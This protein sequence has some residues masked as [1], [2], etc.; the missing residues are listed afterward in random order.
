MRTAPTWPLLLATLSLTL[1]ACGDKGDDDDTGADTGASGTDVD[2]D[3]FD[4]SVDCDDEDPAVNPGATEICDDADV[5][6]DCSGDADDADAGVDT[7]TQTEAFP[8]ADADGYGDAAATATLYCDAPS[9]MVADATD[10]DDTDAAVNPGA[11][12]VC[13]DADVDEDCS[14]AADDA[15]AGVDTSTMTEVFPDDDADGYGDD[16]AAGASYCDP[17]SGLV[18]DASDCD[19]ANGDISPAATEVCDGVDN[20]CDGDA[21]TG[22]CTTCDQLSILTYYQSFSSV[23]DEPADAA[24]AEL[25]AT[26]TATS[27]G[28]TFG[29]EYD[30]ATWDIIV[31]DAP[32]SS[33]PTDV[34]A[35][36][37]TQ[38]SSGGVVLFSWWDLDSDASLATTLGVTV[39]SS[40]NTPMQMEAPST[41]TLWSIAETLP[42][43]IA[44]YSHDAGDN[45]DIV[46]ADDP[47][48]SEQ[49]AYFDGDTSMNAITAT[50]SGQVIVNGF[51]PWDFQD[52]DDNANG[53]SDMVELFINEIAWTTGCQP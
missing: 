45:G 27:N 50:Y 7:T 11:T 6:E 28:S 39:T 43:A 25:G 31:I 16:S 17:P 4:A 1:A 5:D 23:A 35:R 20:D 34:T 13:D 30:A 10:C 44:N 9:G 26:H 18:A 41:S 2:G 19:D 22:V 53:T 40:F 15:D 8:D 24:A 51:L 29:T 36:I 48:T 47:S 46:T 42:T 49:L 12:E 33:L 14:G 52:T 38:I 21:D 37:A 3:G 32:G